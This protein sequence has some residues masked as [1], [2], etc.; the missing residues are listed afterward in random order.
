MVNPHLAG[1]E[2][3][4]TQHTDS[5]QFAAQDATGF[6]SSTGVGL[7]QPQEAPAQLGGNDQLAKGVHHGICKD[8]AEE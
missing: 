7:G 6:H 5:Y 4:L 3:L 8:H 2:Q 1:H